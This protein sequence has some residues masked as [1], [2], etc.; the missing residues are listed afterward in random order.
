MQKDIHSD[1]LARLL[2]NITPSFWA[3]TSRPQHASSVATPRNDYKEDKNR[4]RTIVELYTAGDYKMVEKA[5][6]D[7]SDN[8][9][10]S[11]SFS[12]SN[13]IKS[14]ALQHFTALFEKLLNDKT[15]SQEQ[16]DKILDKLLSTRTVA[17]STTKTEM[18]HSFIHSV[19][20]SPENCRTY[21]AI[22]AYTLGEKERREAAALVKQL[23]DKTFDIATMHGIIESL[24]D[25]NFAS[26]EFMWKKDN[27]LGGFGVLGG[28][29]WKGQVVSGI[30]AL[31]IREIQDKTLDLYRDQHKDLMT[32]EL[33]KTKKTYLFVRETTNPTFSLSSSSAGNAF[34]RET[35]RLL[36]LSKELSKYIPR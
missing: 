33:M 32:S 12:N 18:I 9:G 24:S 23:I 30:W 10:T 27:G 6:Q 13:K 36:A 7:Y 5:L 21:M 28:Y 8:K 26:W 14:I 29:K 17:H 20:I 31:M 11:D 2:Q 25:D 16:R 19:P 22:I 4:Y 35:E 1:E 34:G 3:E 15:I